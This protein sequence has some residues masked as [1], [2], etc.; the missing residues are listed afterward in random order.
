MRY[1]L[2][3][4]TIFLNLLWL[5]NYFKI[6]SIYL[7]IYLHGSLGGSNFSPHP[8][9]HLLSK[10]SYVAES[11]RTKCRSKW[12]M[13]FLVPVHWTLHCRPLPTVFLGA[14]CQHLRW[15]WSLHQP[16]DMK[17]RALHVSMP[18]QFYMSKKKHSLYHTTEISGFICYTNYCTLGNTWRILK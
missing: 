4:C 15:L 18:T 7:T 9:I 10:L 17:H 14:E 3:F 2:S 8:L 16:D 11:W 12:C 1:K 13:P 5:C 6:I